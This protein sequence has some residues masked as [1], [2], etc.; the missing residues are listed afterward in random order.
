MSIEKVFKIRYYQFIDHAFNFTKLIFWNSTMMMLVFFLNGLAFGGLGLASYLQ[1][2]QGSDLP[3]S[4][5]LPWLTAFGFACA[6]THWADMFLAST[7][8]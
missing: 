3:L 1:Y 7:T 2:R 8:T 6:I 5:H 4:K